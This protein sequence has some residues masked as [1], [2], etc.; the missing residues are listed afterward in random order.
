MKTID[1]HV[2]ST[3]SDGTLS[4]SE[5][6]KLAIKK[7][8]SAFALTDHDTIDGLP[9]A[10][11]VALEM[12][13]QNIDLTVIPGIEL[14]A[15]YFEKE[16]HILGLYINYEDISFRKKLN[17]ILE[18]RNQ[19]NLK[20]IENLAKDGIDISIEKIR[21]TYG[22]AVITRAHLANFLAK[23]HYI[24]TPQDAF[25]YYLN[26]NGPYYVQRNYLTP[27]HAISEILHYGGI[28]ILV[29]PL[30][31]HFSLED[32]DN[33][34]NYLK[35]LGL[36]GLEAIYSANKGYDEQNMKKLAQKYDLLIT[37]GSDF[38][39]SNKPQLDLGTG[40]GNLKIPYEILD[41][42]QNW[43]KQR[44]SYKEI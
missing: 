21:D 33:L 17:T 31:Y 11:A 24:K 2:H 18:E 25:G 43:L 27:E 8:L 38:H 12:K 7:Q 29:H 30:L 28:P 44:P 1:L 5:L 41:N 40:Y 23:Q 22:T 39:G 19:R 26:P 6:V 34:V 35:E 16:I 42:L 13:Q 20:M 9:E 10:M 32:L 37:G 14:S 4:P 3:A 36:V 15:K